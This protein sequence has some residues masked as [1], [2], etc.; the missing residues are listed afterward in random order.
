MSLL[1]A[2]VIYF[3]PC[4]HSRKSI[5]AWPLKDPTRRKSRTS[6]CQVLVGRRQHIGISLPPLLTEA[7]LLLKQS[8]SKSFD[9][10]P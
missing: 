8:F 2:S 7:D 10:V 6:V 1:G 5:Q 4:H 3:E 9:R